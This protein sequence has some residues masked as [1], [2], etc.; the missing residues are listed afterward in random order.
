MMRLDRQAIVDAA[1]KVVV[2]M[3]G[4]SAEREISLQS[5]AAVLRALQDCGVDARG[6]DAAEDVVAALQGIRPDRVFNMLHGRGG[7]DGSMQGLLQIMQ[8]PCTGSGV[9]ASAIAMDKLRSKQIWQ[10]MGLPTPPYRR[11]DNEADLAKA[12]Q[13]P[14]LPMIVKPV[15]EGSSIGMSKVETE[16]ELAPAWRKAR[17][18]GCV[19]AEQWIQGREFTAA[20]LHGE[21]LPMIELKTANRFYDYDA[22]YLSDETRYLCPTDLGAAREA[23]LGRLIRQAFDA[24]GASG[25]GRVDFMLDENG[26]PW[27]IEINTVP[28]MTSHSLVPMAAREAGLDFN[29]LV[30]AILQ[31]A[32]ADKSEGVAA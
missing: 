12:L 5:G 8:I 7:E 15:L 3:G 14:G 6:V 24:V 2:L 31:T 32:M 1:G 18:S 25:W 21:V 20:V 11:L 19:I 29:D 9:M 28:G 13:Q 10:A 17:A 16:S 23:E 4:H 27:L 26:Q 30:L 22:K